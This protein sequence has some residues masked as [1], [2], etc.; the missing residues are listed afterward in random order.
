M[1]AELLAAFEKGKQELHQ[2]V[3]AVMTDAPDYLAKLEALA[4]SHNALQAVAQVLE[5]L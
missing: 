5:S 1:K 4:T 3:D 2:A